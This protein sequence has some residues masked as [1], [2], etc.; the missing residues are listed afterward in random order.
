[1]RITDDGI[2][3]N[4]NTE[5]VILMKRL[6]SVVESVEQPSNLT[7]AGKSNELQNMACLVW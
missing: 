1:M 2:N 7:V 4:D 3:H 5:D 6:Q